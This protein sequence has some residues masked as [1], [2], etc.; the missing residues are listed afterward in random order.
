MAFLYNIHHF[1]ILRLTIPDFCLTES[2]KEIFVDGDTISALMQDGEVIYA[3]DLDPEISTEAI[4]TWIDNNPFLH[5]KCL[6]IK[7]KTLVQYKG[8]K[9]TKTSHYVHRI[10]SYVS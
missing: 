9:K 8:K 7:V 2:V 4:R 10:K 5:K 3:T 6:F 1:S